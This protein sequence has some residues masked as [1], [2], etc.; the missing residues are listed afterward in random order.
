M[1]MKMEI[2]TARAMQEGRLVHLDDRQDHPVG[3]RDHELRRRAVR[4]APGHGRNTPPRPRRASARWRSIQ[5]ANDLRPIASANAPAAR[6]VA[7]PMNG[8]PSRAKFTR[9]SPPSALRRSAARMP[10]GIARSWPQRPRPGGQGPGASPFQ[11]PCMPLGIEPVAKW[12]LVEARLRLAGLVP[13]GRPEPRAVGGQHLVD[14]QG[15]PV[16]AAELE[17]CV[18]DDDAARRSEVASAAVHEPGKALEFRGE[19]RRRAASR[20][21]PA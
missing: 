9:R 6:S 12:L 8:Y 14:Q 1:F 20:P 2:R 7:P 3:R 17:L 19:C 10:R 5:T 15:A 16:D 4:S 18:G 21:A 11:R 13:V